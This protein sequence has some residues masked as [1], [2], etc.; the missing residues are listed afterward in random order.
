MPAR[1]KTR[2][3]NQPAIAESVMPERSEVS[4]EKAK[5][6]YVVSSFGPNGREMYVEK[7]KTAAKSRASRIL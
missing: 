1:K 2:K 6:G 4:I 3:T 7:T 5:N